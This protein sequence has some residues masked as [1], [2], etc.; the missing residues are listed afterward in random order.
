MRDSAVFFVIQWIRLQFSPSA[1]AWN[2]SETDFCKLIEQRLTAL[3]DCY[4]R[5]ELSFKDPSSSHQTEAM[6]GVGGPCHEFSSAPALVNRSNSRS[7]GEG[8]DVGR[9]CT[10][11]LELKS[12]RA[13]WASRAGRG[14]NRVVQHARQTRTVRPECDARR[15]R[16]E[17]GSREKGGLVEAREAEEAGEFQCFNYWLNFLKQKVRISAITKLSIE[18]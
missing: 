7:S 12:S 13:E 1:R 2:R 17:G 5:K 6:E 4:H 8:G 15:D 11:P 9:Q 14:R 10:V 18:K 16:E 3:T